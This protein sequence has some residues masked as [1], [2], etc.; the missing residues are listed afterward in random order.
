MATVPQD[1]SVV[2]RIAIEMQKLLRAREWRAVA[3]EKVRPINSEAIVIRAYRTP[4]KEG[5]KGYRQEATPG[6]IIT[7]PRRIFRPGGENSE[8][9]VRYQLL[10]QI[11]DENPDESDGLHTYAKW[12]Q[13]ISRLFSRTDLDQTVFDEDGYVYYGHA[14]E[15]DVFD[16]SLFNRHDLAVCGVMVDFI[17][18]EPSLA[19]QEDS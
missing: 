6:L 5:E 11:V 7:L 9:E 10:V 14:T 15:L 16:D 18:N 17:S 4:Q 3:H 8:D 1:L 19:E 2:S 13:T 12:Q